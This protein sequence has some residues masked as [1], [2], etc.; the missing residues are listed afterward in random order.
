MIWSVDPRYGTSER[1]ELKIIDDGFTAS[2]TN[3]GEIRA[4]SEKYVDRPWFHGFERE[5]ERRI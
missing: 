2:C 3:D 1:S 4:A 5:R